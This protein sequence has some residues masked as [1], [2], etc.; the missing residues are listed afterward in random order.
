MFLLCTVLPRDSGRVR[1]RAVTV[2]LRPGAGRDCRT[3]DGYG[4]AHMRPKASAKDR[5]AAGSGV[6]FISDVMHCSTSYYKVPH[7]HDVDGYEE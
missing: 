2:Q 3:T 6:V 1:V 7:Q 4:R 5:P